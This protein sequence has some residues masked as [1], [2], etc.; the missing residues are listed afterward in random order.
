MDDT[1]ESGEN[2]ARSSQSG[3][4]SIADSGN[5][6]VRFDQAGIEAIVD[7]SGTVFFRQLSDVGLNMSDHIVVNVPTAEVRA[8]AMSPVV[9]VSGGV[10]FAISLNVALVMLE[11][12]FSGQWALAEGVRPQA[13][14]EIAITQWLVILIVIAAVCRK[15][16]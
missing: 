14:A 10:P 13:V 6:S 2:V 1:H 11:P 5:V 16:D 9:V 12:I 3:S 8:E 4:E 15:R 7:G